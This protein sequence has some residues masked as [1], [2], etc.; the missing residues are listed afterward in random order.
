VV[1]IEVGKQEVKRPSLAD[2]ET[3]KQEGE[4]CSVATGEAGEQEFTRSRWAD[5]EIWRQSGQ[6]FNVLAREAKCGKV[7]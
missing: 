5:G 3:W 4:R 6:R 1:D 7:Q 2:R